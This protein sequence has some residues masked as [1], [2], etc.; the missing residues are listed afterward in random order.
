MLKNALI[1]FSLFCA[2]IFNFQLEAETETTQEVLEAE[3]VFVI[4]EVFFV[5]QHWFSLTNTFDIRSP[6]AKLGT[7][8]RRLFSLTVQYD[9][10]DMQK[11]LQSS[12]RMRFFSFGAIFDVTDKHEG[13]L[14]T[15]EQKLFCFFPTFELFSPERYSLAI[16]KMNFWGTK[17]TLFDPRTNEPFAEMTRPFFRFKDD[18]TVTLAYPGILNEKNIDPRLFMI[19]IA[20]QTDREYWRRKAYSQHHHQLNL[21]PLFVEDGFVE[22][23][24]NLQ[25]SDLRKNFEAYRPAL[26]VGELE[27]AEKDVLFIENYVDD[28]LTLAGVESSINAQEGANFQKERSYQGLKVLMTILD[29]D[30]LTDGQKK[31]LFFMI[32]IYLNQFGY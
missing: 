32:D 10:Y 12:A 3:R 17:Y 15:V 29:E 2:F 25:L 13:L 14:G 20:Y 21:A 28:Y 30:R 4:P 18:W 31:A 24:L 27:L 23:G 16:A 22:E 7:L 6:Y 9:F 8:H 11:E 5:D 26:G 19:V 1:L